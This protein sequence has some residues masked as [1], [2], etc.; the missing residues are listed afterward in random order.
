MKVAAQLVTDRQRHHGV[1]HN[2]SISKLEKVDGND[3]GE[4]AVAEDKREVS[5]EDRVQWK[6]HLNDVPTDMRMISYDSHH[7]SS[8][9]LPQLK[10]QRDS[11]S[12]PREDK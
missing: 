6:T 1:L 10:K 9:M 11:S 4:E 5:N 8:S 3:D 7:G 2:G 12:T